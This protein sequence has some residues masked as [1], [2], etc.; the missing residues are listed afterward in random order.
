MSATVLV[1]PCDEDCKAP[2]PPAQGS[3]APMPA[4]LYNDFVDPSMIGRPR[5]R[6]P[7]VRPWISIRR[8]TQSTDARASVDFDTAAYSIYGRT[9]GRGFRY[10]GLLNL[11][12]HARPWISIRRPTQST[13]ARAAVDFDTAA[14]SIYGR[15]R[16]RATAPKRQIATCRF[17][18]PMLG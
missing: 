1:A 10:G 16:G 9:R 4:A 8:P 2:L 6:R 7:R 3:C 12:T 13:D 18:Q 17:F 15:T 11:R 5:L 14:Y